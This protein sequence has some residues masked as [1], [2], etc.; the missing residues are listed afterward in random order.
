MGLGIAKGKAI[1]MV[2]SSKVPERKKSAVAKPRN[3]R[4]L[5]WSKLAKSFTTLIQGNVTA[6]MLQSI[7][8]GSFSKVENLYSL[9]QKD[10]TTLRKLKNA[11]AENQRTFIEVACE[12]ATT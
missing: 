5:S 1:L 11:R 12:L 6:K 10:S 8:D 4:S 2:N 9:A 3:K 7:D